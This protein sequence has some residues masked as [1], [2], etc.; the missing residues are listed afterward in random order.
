MVADRYERYAIS[1]VPEG[2]QISLWQALPSLGFEHHILQQ[3]D[4][5][6]LVGDAFQDLWDELAGPEHLIWS[7]P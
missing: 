5:G 2:L 6:Q 1:H 7:K 3:V 4:N